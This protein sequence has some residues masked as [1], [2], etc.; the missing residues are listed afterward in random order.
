MS[1]EQASALLGELH[2]IRLAVTW[3]AGLLVL[4]TIFAAVRTFFVVRRTIDRQLDDL[5]RQDAQTLLEKNDLEKLIAQCRDHL[6]VRPNHAYAR[7]YLARALLLREEWRLASEELAVLR[8]KY[9]DWANSIAPL[10]NEARR[11]IE[12]ADRS[13]V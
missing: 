9:P 4:S 13:P 2:N 12:G 3:A 6:T 7:W 5:F 10:A 8:E 11:K 1:T